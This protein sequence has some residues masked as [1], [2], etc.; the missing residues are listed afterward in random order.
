MYSCVCSFYSLVSC[1]VLWTNKFIWWTENRH[2]EKSHYARVTVLT[3]D[4][5][6]QNSSQTHYTAQSRLSTEQLDI[7][8]EAPCPCNLR[9]PRPRILTIPGA[10]WFRALKITA[11][12][13]TANCGIEEDAALTWMASC[14]KL[15]WPMAKS[16]I[17][18]KRTQSVGRQRWQ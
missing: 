6:K 14:S 3:A 10:K 11:L 5:T 8:L 2:E 13:D 15:I 4:S 18:C 9:N 12:W 7:P 17:I 1:Y 16:E